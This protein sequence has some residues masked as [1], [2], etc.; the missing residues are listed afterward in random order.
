MPLRGFAR[1][2]LWWR[3]WLGLLALTLV[4]CLLPLPSVPIPMS[5]FDK[6]EHGL[7]YA[8]LSAYAAMLFASGRGVALAAIGLA[9]YGG[10]IE[11]LQAAVPWRGLD[12]LDAAFNALG[13]ALG[14]MVWFTPAAGALHW[15][16]R[17]LQ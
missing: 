6:F 9:V 16:D 10:V 8:A 2:R 1:P 15:V 13:A 14:A 7:G 4:V 11:L 12:P 17:R 5:H 3:L